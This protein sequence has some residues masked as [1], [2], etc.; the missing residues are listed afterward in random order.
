MKIR[1][2][3]K[4]FTVPEFCPS[5]RPKTDVLRRFIKEHGVEAFVA[6]EKYGQYAA[7]LIGELQDRGAEVIFEMSNG[8][9]PDDG[10]ADTV[11]MQANSEEP[12]TE[13]TDPHPECLRLAAPEA[14]SRRQVTPRTLLEGV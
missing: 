8:L 6:S 14:P 9:R 2:T 10:P 13:V 11:Q 12:S 5:E 3:N 1:Y 7:C 4:E